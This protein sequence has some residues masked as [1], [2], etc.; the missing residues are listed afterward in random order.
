MLS[1]FPE[2][3]RA[4]DDEDVEFLEEEQRKE[5]ERDEQTRRQEK[6]QLDAFAVSF[7]THSLLVL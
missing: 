2:P 4:L 7:E 1:F 6:L 3:P 5:R